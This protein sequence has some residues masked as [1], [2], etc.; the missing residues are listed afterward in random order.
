MESGMDTSI[1]QV[2]FADEAGM[3]ARKPVGFIREMQRTLSNRIFSAPSMTMTMSSFCMLLSSKTELSSIL[4]Q[5]GSTI[6]TCS[7][8]ICRGV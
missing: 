8:D 3:L 6:A 5:L 7:T 1:S 2:T 4:L